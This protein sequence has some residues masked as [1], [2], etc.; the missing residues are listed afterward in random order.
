MAAGPV[1][2]KPII[3]GIG[4]AQCLLVWTRYSSGLL[5][6]LSVCDAL[7]VNHGQVCPEL[8]PQPI[9]FYYMKGWHVTWLQ[10]AYCRLGWSL[11]CN[12]HQVQCTLG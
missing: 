6:I 5:A 4:S 10:F 9:R 8:S 2:Q 1:G 12:L 11:I 7:V 3:G